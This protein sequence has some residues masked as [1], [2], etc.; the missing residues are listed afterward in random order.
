MN[1]VVYI[2]P[3]DIIS[4]ICLQRHDSNNVHYPHLR[5]R[6]KSLSRYGAGGGA[7]PLT[8]QKRGYKIY[9]Y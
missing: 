3:Y 8:M 6:D 1:T 4:W 7:A 5:G 9:F 2:Y